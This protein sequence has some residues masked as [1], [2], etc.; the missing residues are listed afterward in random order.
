MLSLQSLQQLHCLTATEIMAA[1][2]HMK[3]LIEL[4]I[5]PEMKTET[6][7]DPAHM[8]EELEVTLTA[9]QIHTQIENT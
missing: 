7:Q 9:T 5:I 6:A 4:M 1:L 8:A 2:E 3:A